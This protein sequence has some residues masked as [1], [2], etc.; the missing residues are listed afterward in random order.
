MS[1][2]RRLVGL[3]TAT[4]LL[5]SAAPALAT[6]TQPLALYV[7]GRELFLPQ[8]PILK[9][10]RVLVPMRAYLESLGAEVGWEPP[11]LVTAALGGR[12]VQLRIGE[13]T[14]LVDGRS[15][16]LDVP[17][18]LI[19]DR[20]YVPLR[21]LSEGLGATVEYDGEAAAVTVQTAPPGQLE[22]IDGPLNVRQSPSTS[23]P[24]LMTVPLGTRLE[25]VT[26]EPGSE[27]TE[28]LL[29][30]GLRGWVANRYTR[31][32]GSQPVVE[33]F[34]PIL[35]QRAFLQAGG[36]CVGAVP[37]IADLTLVPLA[38]TMRALGGSLE[39]TED[40]AGMRARLS[41]RE[42]MLVPG[43]VEGWLDGQ[44]RILTAAP[45]VVGGRPFVAARDVADIF[46]LPLSWS[47]ATHTVTIG[48]AGTVCNPPAAAK[49]YIMMDAATGAVLSEYNARDPLYIASTTKIMT[50][51]LA[52]E[53]GNP[54]SVVTVSSTAASQ[55]GTSVYL[56]AGEQR[57]LGELLYGLMLVSGNDAAVAIA[58]HISG[59]EESF[60]WLMNQRAAELGARNTY[61]VTASGLDDW[62]DPYSTA[63][64][65][66][67]IAQHALQNPRFRSY[68]YP[69]QAVIPGPWGNR[70]LTNSNLFTLRYP[71][72]TG[73]KNGWTEKAAY[74]LVASA[75][76]DG[77]EVL[78]VLLG[79]P[80]RTELYSQAYNLMD[81][82]FILAGQSWLLN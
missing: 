25:I 54:N 1:I 39:R 52:V 79:A 2:R 66:A 81:H 18:Q 76:R 10:N 43:S 68:M 65:L 75:W 13:Q 48:E 55:P 40:G 32:L 42:L 33:P 51:L 9:E 73:V 44:L 62:V 11:D 38:E 4:A 71:G 12:T 28:V 30:G 26:E 23:S 53:R 78:L 41:G 24:I 3:V 70:Q 22:V 50:A 15:V 49:A 45:V 20:T 46:G 8:V 27:W 63:E 16:P 37:I 56:R 74:T 64:D 5:V 21:F 58:E 77:R 6:D 80:T 59:S 29:P 57:T 7:N 34:L 60:A 82:G 36:Q 67:A 17:A 72:A 14:A 61:F 19:E 69:T 31:T 47:D 35:E